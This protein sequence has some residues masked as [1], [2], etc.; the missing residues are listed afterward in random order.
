M[1][2][3]F[4]LVNYGLRFTSPCS[5]RNECADNQLKILQYFMFCP[6][7]LCICFIELL[8]WFTKL[9]FCVRRDLWQLRNSVF[10]NK[11]VDVHAKLMQRYNQVP[12]W[13]FLCILF[14]NISATLFICQYNNDQLQLPWW[15]VLFACVLAFMFTLPVGVIAATTNQVRF[16]LILNLFT[17]EFI[18][19][20]LGIF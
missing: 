8:S 11:T 13:W 7:L 18:L 1:Q 12:E 19:C 2:Y 17:L 10:K 3:G 9:S 5:R 4:I 14:L 6:F 15:G 20:S 16:Y